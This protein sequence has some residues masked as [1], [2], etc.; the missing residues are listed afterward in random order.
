M[1]PKN[2][3]IKPVAKPRLVKNEPK[4]SSRSGFCQ[5]EGHPPGIVQPEYNMPF[6]EFWACWVEITGKD[7]GKE[8]AWMIWAER[9]KYRGLPGLPYLQEALIDQSE[10]EQWAKDKGKYI[11]S[12]K[13]WLKDGQWANKLPKAVGKLGS[14]DFLKQAEEMRQQ[15]RV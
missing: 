3:I 14:A 8:A 7:I 1:A 4:Q 10:S 9:E 6:E 5:R 12:A 2:R 15:G 13:N 11:P